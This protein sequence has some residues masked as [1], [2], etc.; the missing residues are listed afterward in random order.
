MPSALITGITGQDGSYLAEILL[1]RGYRVTGLVR[2]TSSFDPWR[3]AHLLDRVRL[4]DGDLLDHGS[5]LRAVEAAEPDHVSNLA[6]QSFVGRSWN[7]PVLT[8]EVTGLGALRLFEAVRS[9][10]PAARV[11]QASTSEMYGDLGGALATAR[12]PFAPRSPYGTAKLFAHTTGICWRESFGM[13][14]AN[15]ILFN[16]ESPRRGVEFVTRKVCRAAARAALGDRAKLRLG[17]LAARR[18]WGWAPDYAEAMVR[19]LEHDAPLDLVVATGESRSVEDLC[20]AAFAVVG[21]DW[22]AWVEVDPS[23]L[24]P[25]DIGALC[26]DPAPAAEAIGW[27]PTVGFQEMV[28]RM[29]EAELHHAPGAPAAR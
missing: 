20:A 17:N 27:R 4:V 1:D 10:A 21:L 6:A 8:A 7:E 24:R 18:D 22:R 23:L 26:G 11:Y 25:N 28:K 12:G 5:L 15:G 3:I 9:A 29:V 16:H 14:V 13:F 19:M 2:R